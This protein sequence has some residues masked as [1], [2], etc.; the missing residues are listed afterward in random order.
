MITIE[1]NDELIAIVGADA[2]SFSPNHNPDACATN[3]ST[4]ATSSHLPW[5]DR[6]RALGVVP[7]RD[8]A[9]NAR[10]PPNALSDPLRVTESRDGGRVTG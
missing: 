6:R 7:R 3:H 5:F 10:Q 2:V 4:F 1:L 9:A 8:A